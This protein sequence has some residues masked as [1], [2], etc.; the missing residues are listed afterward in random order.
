MRPRPQQGTPPSSVTRKRRR[1]WLLPPA[2][3]VSPRL[4][5]INPVAPEDDAPRR[6]PSSHAVIG[7]DGSQRGEHDSPATP[8]HAAATAATFPLGTPGK[9]RTFAILLLF[10]GIPC[11]AAAALPRAAAHKPGAAGAPLALFIR[12][13]RFE[14]T[15]ASFPARRRPNSIIPA[16][17]RRDIYRRVHLLPRRRRRASVK[18]IPEDLR[19]NKVAALIDRSQFDEINLRGYGF[20]GLLPRRY[21]GAARPSSLRRWLNSR[22][23]SQVDP[24]PSRNSVM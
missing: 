12:S 3:G 18:F 5:R 4:F 8:L 15:I 2:A 14:G 17:M 10:N 9:H 19:L 20:L 11:R 23:L 24:R 22:F 16:M 1:R 13:R 6:R 21:R 7:E